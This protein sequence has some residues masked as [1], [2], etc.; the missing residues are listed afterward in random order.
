MLVSQ[1]HQLALLISRVYHSQCS[2][3]H[4]TADGSQLISST[5][6]SII[7][8]TVELVCDVV[9]KLESIAQKPLVFIDLEGV[10][11]SREGVIAIMQILVPPNPVVQLVDIY[12]LGKDAFN[13]SR[14]GGQTLRGILES[15]D[16]A[17]VF[18]DVRN[19]LDA[20][21]S[22]YQVILSGV[23]DL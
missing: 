12:T 21:Y 6:A 13:T 8:D 2:A 1:T 4:H 15:K 19:D 10:N 23:I 17:K 18:F 20:L 11:L 3:T 5:M 7:V 14:P 22:H 16:Y 9:E